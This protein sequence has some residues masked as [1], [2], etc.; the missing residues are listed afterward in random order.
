MWTFL[1]SPFALTIMSL[2]FGAF[3]S[4]RLSHTWQKRKI[5]YELQVALV[6]RFSLL[7][8][9]Y[10]RILESKNMNKLA[11]EYFDE[12]HAELNSIALESRVVF[13]TITIGKK[14][15]DLIAKMANARN[16]TLNTNKDTDKKLIEIHQLYSKLSIRL[17][18]ELVG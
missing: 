4:S 15:N 12:I 10:I 9:K 17:Q 11:G 8:Q 16:L 5:R 14:I 13:K 2:F 6:K 3:V 18:Q 7:F 1:N